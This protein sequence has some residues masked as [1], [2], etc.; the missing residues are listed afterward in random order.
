MEGERGPVERNGKTD[1]W[2]KVG[3]HLFVHCM[4][5]PESTAE[6]M[7]AAAKYTNIT[8]S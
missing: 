3:G 2:E 8:M 7:N 4:C 6:E 5:F 1:G